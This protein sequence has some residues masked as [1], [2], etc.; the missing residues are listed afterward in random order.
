MPNENLKLVFKSN[1]YDVHKCNRI[2]AM[3]FKDVIPSTLLIDYKTIC[4]SKKD[5]NYLQQKKQYN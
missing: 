4:F 3:L 1:I 5:E 2:L